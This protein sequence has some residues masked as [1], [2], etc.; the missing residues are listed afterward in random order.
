MLGNTLIS[1]LCFGRREPVLGD[2][3]R[4]GKNDDGNDHDPD[5]CLVEDIDRTENILVVADGDTADERGIK[6]Q[7]DERACRMDQRIGAVHR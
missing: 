4:N 7:A 1:M 6:A 5:A 3:A 2:H